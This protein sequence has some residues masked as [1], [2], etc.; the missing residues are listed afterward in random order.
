MNT[1]AHA[2]SSQ[3]L[4]D[5]QNSPSSVALDID[6]VGVKHVELPLVVKDRDKGHQHT[7]ASVDMGVD[8]PAAFKGTH[9][10]RFVE[11]LENWR[12]ASSEELDYASAR[13]LLKDTLERLHAHRA[14]VRFT[15]P[16]FRARKA[17]VTGYEAPVRYTCKLTGEMEEHQENPSILL[18]LEVPVTTVC[19]CSKAIS[20]A[21]AHG[22]RAMVRMALRMSRF[23]WLEGF[24]DIA[25]S[26]GSAPIYTLL[27]RPDEKFV[28][29]QAYDNALFVEDVVRNVAARLKEHPHITWFRVEVESEESI[30]GH[31]AF[32]GIERHNR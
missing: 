32:A 3:S 22:Q 30:H 11:A 18:E 25:E 5:V 29:E 26:S 13:R 21:G 1:T 23:E 14:Y 2:D 4:T 17:P 8:L 24:I 31:N 20:R 15:F 7:V 6:R 9:M 28:T 10:S 12:E 16:Y 19:P 27:K